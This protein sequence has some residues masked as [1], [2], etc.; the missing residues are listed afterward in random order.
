MKKD[1]YV[2]QV[3]GEW[4]P[5]KKGST[6]DNMSFRRAAPIKLHQEYAVLYVDPTDYKQYRVHGDVVLIETKLVNMRTSDQSFFRGVELTPTS[7][8]TLV[9]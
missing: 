5:D 4:S 8:K 6:K 9:V 2:D 3:M 1:L 7:I